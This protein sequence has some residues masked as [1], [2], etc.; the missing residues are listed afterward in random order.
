M[1]SRRIIEH[2]LDAA[3]LRI[4]SRVW[5]DED[6]HSF[7]AFDL[8]H[9]K[10]SPFIALM[11]SQLF[12][13]EFIEFHGMVF[14][15]WVLEDDEDRARVLAK[16][17]QAD[18]TTVQKEFNFVEVSG[19]FGAGKAHTTAEEDRLLADYLAAMWRAKLAAEPALKDARVE[20]TEPDDA[21]ETGLTIYRS[22]V[23]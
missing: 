22:D 13:P 4:A 14:L 17:R 7:S 15:P 21:N 10:G 11:Y 19:L 20:V 8:L 1:N 2:G 16:L 6:F 12:W 23:S 3:L 18:E 5:P 9:A